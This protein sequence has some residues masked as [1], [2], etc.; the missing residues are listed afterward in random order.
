MRNMGCFDF[1]FVVF[2]FGGCNCLYEKK[3]KNIG[4]FVEGN[5]DV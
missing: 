3:I 2:I 5:K 1:L 4:F